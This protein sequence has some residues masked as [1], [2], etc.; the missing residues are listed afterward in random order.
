M[1][2]FTQTYLNLGN[3]ANYLSLGNATKKEIYSENDYI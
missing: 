2:T 3:A 1:N